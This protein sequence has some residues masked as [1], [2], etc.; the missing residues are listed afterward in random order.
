MAAAIRLVLAQELGLP[1]RAASQLSI[2]K[3]R[4]VVGVELLRAL[5]VRAGYRIERVDIS[6]ESCTVAVIDERGA[7]PREMGRSTF[8]MDDAKRAGLVRGGGAYETHPQRMLWA[9]AAGYAMRDYI[10]E[11]T[12]GLVTTDEAVELRTAYDLEA[13][14]IEIDELAPEYPPTEPLTPDEMAPTADDLGALAHEGEEPPPATAS[15]ER[16][17]DPLGLDPVP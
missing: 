10:P 14:A 15:Y 1:M 17:D 7:E 6:D 11:V 12:M 2:V 5:A 8:T 3:G 9:R 13:E 16:P 4:L